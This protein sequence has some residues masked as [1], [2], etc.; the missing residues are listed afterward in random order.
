[1]L[2]TVQT[3]NQPIAKVQT[4]RDAAEQDNNNGVVVYVSK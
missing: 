2:T 1:M 4:Y 3:V